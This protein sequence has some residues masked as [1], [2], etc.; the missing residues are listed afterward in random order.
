[1]LIGRISKA[2]EADVAVLTDGGLGGDAIESIQTAVRES[3]NRSLSIALSAGL[4]SLRQDQAA[5]EYEIAL[6]RLDATGRS[7]VEDALAGN[8]TSLTALEPALD[9]HG[10]QVVRSQTEQLRRT[11]ATL[12]VNLLGIVNVLTIRELVRRGSVLVEPQTGLLVLSDATTS[13]KITVVSKPF[14]ADGQKLR[15]ILFENFLVTAALRAG[16]LGSSLEMESSYTF[17][18]FHAGTNRQTMSDHLDAVVGA[19]LISDAR[20]REALADLR[21]FGPSTF[22]LEAVFGN[23]ACTALF[24]GPDGTPRPEEFYD[25][26]GREALVA[27]VRP[28]DEADFRAIPPSDDGVWARMREAG[29]AALELALPAS[30]RRPERVAVIRADFAQIRWWATSMHRVSVKLAELRALVAGA[31][32]ET[33]R[34]DERFGRL[35]KELGTLLADVVK[36]SGSQFGDPWGLLALNGAA[37][38]HPPKKTALIVSP[39]LTLSAAGSEAAAEV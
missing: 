9:D 25:A 30:L 13:K 38:S 17:F 22:L 33:V 34:D 37:A 26:A 23:D 4:S 29:P 11:G 35:H 20:K 2:P 15:K 6:D 14:E 19:G 32:F 36:R 28:G 21:D 24:L 8:F 27:L 12:K 3:V 1:M 16:A 10:I 18:E 39:R 31:T 7:A 5:F